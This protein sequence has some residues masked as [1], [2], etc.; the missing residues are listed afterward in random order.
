M[1]DPGVRFGNPGQRLAGMAWPPNGL[2]V[3]SRRLLVR[4]G[5]FNPSV[6]GGLPLCRPNWRSNAATRTAGTA[7]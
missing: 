4:G 1:V 3:G 5:F 6:E 2:S 7:F